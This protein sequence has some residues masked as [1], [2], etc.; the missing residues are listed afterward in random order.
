MRL[1]TH[2]GGD[3]RDEGWAQSPLPRRRAAHPQVMGAEWLSDSPAVVRGPPPPRRAQR[4][5]PHWLPDQAESGG[6]HSKSNNCS[7]PL[8]L[9][10]TGFNKHRKKAGHSLHNFK[11]LELWIFISLFGFAQLLSR[12]HELTPGQQPATEATNPRQTQRLLPCMTAGPQ[13]APKDGHG[14]SK[15]AQETPAC[16]RGRSPLPG[17]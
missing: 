15:S 16:N 12:V 17:W 9:P 8:S 2:R 13:T 5:G 7:K 11:P 14:S 6:A 10:L 1:G 4:C 3:L